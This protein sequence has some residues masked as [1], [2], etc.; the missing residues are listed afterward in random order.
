MLKAYP[1][2]ARIRTFDILLTLFM[3]K[4]G[5]MLVHVA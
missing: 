2:K 5:C 4:V 1:G 3:Q